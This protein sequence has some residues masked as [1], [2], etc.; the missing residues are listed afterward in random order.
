MNVSLFAKLMRLSRVHLLEKPDSR[1]H[2]RRTTE[3]GVRGILMRAYQTRSNCTVVRDCRRGMQTQPS[4]WSRIRPAELVQPSASSN[5][6]KQSAVTTWELRVQSDKPRLSIV[7]MSLYCYN[8]LKVCRNSN[9][10]YRK[11]IT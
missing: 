1:K 3:T 9:A 11:P 5:T 6:S 8:E 10:K 4:S 7:R 2:L